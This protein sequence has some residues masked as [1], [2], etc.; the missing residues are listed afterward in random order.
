MKAAST[1]RR[2]AALLR[3]VSPMNAKMSE[4]TRCFE[5]AGFTGVKTVLSS[6]NVVFSAKS[7]KADSLQSKAEAAMAKRL[8]RTFMTIVRPIDTLRE[9]LD[10]DPYSRFELP[11]AAKRI[12]T[13]LRNRGQ[14]TVPLPFEQDGVRILCQI[15]NE[16]FSAYVPGPRGPVFMTL[17][18]KKF[19]KEITT[20]TWETVRKV[21]K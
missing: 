14:A 12:V 19:G 7:A 11:S 17:L 15:G 2:Y 9:L 16:V 13:F 20:R 3:G 10:A 1:T 8:G 18:E 21:A 6:G 5:A 4:L